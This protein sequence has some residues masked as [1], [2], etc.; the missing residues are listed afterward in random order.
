MKSLGGIKAKLFLLTWGM[1]ILPLVASGALAYLITQRAL[2]NRAKAELQAAPRTI[3]KRMET[4]MGYRLKM[5]QL[6]AVTPAV[7]LGSPEE[8]TAYFHQILK[9]YPQYLWIG[10]TDSEGRIVAATDPRSLGQNVS[11]IAW[12]QQCKATLR[13]GVCD[14]Y[15]HGPAVL[16]PLTARDFPHIGFSAPLLDPQGRFSGVLHTDVKMEIIA[17]HLQGIQ[18]GK[19]GFVLLIGPQGE[20]IADVY[21]PTL[22]SKENA[23]SLSAYRLAHS[24]RTGIVR[25]ADLNDKDSFIS[26]AP[27]RGPASP[28]G[29][30]ILA[31][32]GTD[33]IFSASRAQLKLFA[34]ILLLGTLFILAGSFFLLGRGIAEPI[35]RLMEGVGTVGQGDFSYRVK[36]QNRDELGRLAEAFNDMASTLEKK[37]KALQ[38]KG[39]EL[40]DYVYAISHDLRS[41]LCS[42]QGFSGLLTNECQEALGEDGRRYLQRIRA[43]AQQM[44]DL[45]ESLLEL[46]RAG[47]MSPS[48]TWELPQWI[49]KEVQEEMSCQLEQEKVKLVIHRDLPPIN[50]DRKGIRQVFAN[51]IQ[52]AIS[53]VK[54]APSPIIEVGYVENGSSD[55]QFYV[56]DNG[57]GI[58]RIYHQQIFQPFQSLFSQEGK[59]KGEERKG[60]GLAIVKKIVQ[61]HGGK[62]WVESEP[63]QGASF[64]FTMPTAGGQKQ[65]I[66]SQEEKP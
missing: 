5:A 39:E 15:T 43:N 21:G 34:V 19:S 55:H 61:S 66:N 35:E 42:I 4:F 27:L 58:D 51:L 37:G 36:V 45:I 33:E 48:L 64:H 53:A 31:I 23:S 13:E 52:N 9:F 25:G 6:F 20:V 44:E 3:A 41:P 56:R 28:L 16:L 32:E 17:E 10:S 22:P 57:I 14:V 40:E 24:G 63:G 1:G 46:S 60:L 47:R 18:I 49:L 12:F 30:S 62:I 50:C 38:E 2:T 8:R 7:A 65:E 54:G 26:F 59:E 11:H 29:W